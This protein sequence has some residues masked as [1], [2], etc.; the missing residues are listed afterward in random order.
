[1]DKK[2]LIDCTK[3]NLN[4]DHEMTEQG[5][6]LIILSCCARSRLL[7]AKPLFDEYCR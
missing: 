5:H 3:H 6:E 7:F 1:M 4:P 2:A